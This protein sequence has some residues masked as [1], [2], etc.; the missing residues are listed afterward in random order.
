MRRSLENKGL[1]E[2]DIDLN[3]WSPVYTGDWDSDTLKRFNN[4]KKA[5][6]L[7]IGTNI[8]LKEITS[9]TG[10]H[11]NDIYR[12]IDKCFKVDNDNKIY[13]YRALI[14][15]LQTDEYQRKT[16]NQEID[17]NYSGSFTLLLKKY[18]VLKDFLIEEYFRASTRKNSA[19][20]LK[21][22]YKNMHRKFIKECK[23]CGIKPS[24]YPFNTASLA[25]KSVK[26]FLIEVS[27]SYYTE[28]AKNNGGQSSMLLKHTNNTRNSNTEILRPL[29]RVEFDGHRIDALFT[30]EFTTPGGEKIS[31]RL[32]RIW[33]LTVED[34]ATRCIIGYHL[35]LRR[36]YSSDDVKKCFQSAII[37]WQP[38]EFT[39]TG[40]NY[41]PDAGFPSYKF[42]EAEYAVWDEICY[43]NAK[44]HL[45][46]EIKDLLQKYIGCS[47]NMGP[48]GVPVKR[49]LVERF[50]NTIEQNT[51]HRL[52]S[53]TG[54]N[55]L[56]PIRN[57]AEKKA[58]KF[59]ITYELIQEL[60]EVV[61]ANYNATPHDSND[62]FTPLEVFESRLDQGYTLKQL[63]E[64]Q[65]NTINLFPLVVNRTVK[66]NLNEGRRPYINFKGSRY[67]SNELSNDFSMVNEKVTIL[68]NT[69]DLRTVEVFRSDGSRYGT[70]RAAGKWGIR[71]HSLKIKDTI[72]KFKRERYFSYTE[73]DDP[74][75]KFQEFLE[76]R[77][78]TDKALRNVLAEY[79]IYNKKYNINNM[80]AETIRK[81]RIINNNHTE[82]QNLVIEQQK[83][84][85]VQNVNKN[86]ENYD[87]Q[88]LIIKQK[89]QEKQ[90]LRIKS[91]EKENPKPNETIDLGKSIVDE[92]NPHNNIDDNDSINK[93]EAS[94]F[95][96]LIEEG[97][98]ART[99]KRR[100]INL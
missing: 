16:E 47:I 3:K 56:D 53:T 85:A 69:E 61:I 94:Y 33:L 80:K 76:T 23:K 46:N 67:S 64:D 66:G 10:I 89:E 88:D 22:S 11:K 9:I 7:F 81:K 37:P 49:P 29:E 32:D 93:L 43:D 19:R 75:D 15:Y 97:R 83:K 82:L 28:V 24:E 98:S 78:I 44:S 90:I 36:E 40:L 30:I 35:C 59:S 6:E 100:S 51:F 1:S 5:I 68:V 25:L 70:F 95:D 79:K 92:Q 63:P 74:M 39:I 52:P 54:S 13:G 65:R 18:P 26:R 8:P 50:F 48:V 57:E 41:A 71:P 45:S 14:P 73:Y 38:K 20:E 58:F 55:P 99:K 2:D 4:R 42:P 72:N 87:V 91:N 96:R 12:F 60:C 21:L 34:V 27:N 86:K 77:A 17:S 62:G 31:S 84:I